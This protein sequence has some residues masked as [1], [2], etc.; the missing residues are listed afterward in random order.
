MGK[1]GKGNEEMKENP[2]KLGIFGGTSEGRL[3]AE[4]CQQQG[5]PA[6]VSVATEYGSQLLKEDAGLKVHIGRMERQEMC[7]WIKDNGFVHVVDATHP[8]AKEASENIKWAC[9]AAGIPYHRLVRSGNGE[10]DRPQ[11]DLKKRKTEEEIHWVSTVEEAA[12]FL[13]M[14]FLKYPKRTALITTGSKELYRFAAIEQAEERLYARVL[15]SI[16][17][18]QACLDAG[19]TGK[20]VI[21]MQGPFSYEMN[22]AMLQSTGASYLITKESGK[23][24]GFQEKADAALAAGCQLVVIGRPVQEQG[25]SLS[26]MEGWLQDAFLRAAP[27]QAERGSGSEER[28]ITLIGIGMGSLG[29]MTFDGILALWNSD[30]ILGASRM[31]ESGRAMLEQLAAIG[32]GREEEAHNGQEKTGS[33]PDNRGEA[34]KSFCVTYRP[35]EMIAWLDDHPKVKHPIILYSG[36]VGFYSGA[37]QFAEMVSRR[38]CRYRCRMLPGISSMAYFAARL[39]RSWDQAVVV[40]LHGREDHENWDLA[41]GRD[42]FLL[43]DGP[44]KLQEVCRR[45]MEQGQSE[46]RIW[47]GE[48]LSYPE[49]RIFSG[50]PGELADR[51]FGRLSVAWIAPAG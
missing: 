15:P 38:P 46:A 8:Y 42:R 40:S 18:I 11:E 5:I 16:E 45:L 50:T 12:D 1:T 13:S 48:R 24:G 7:R 30:A 31:V 39:G 35:E 14:E 51:V 33:K 37:E 36:D 32:F 4:F 20:H 47:I 41:D 44:Q 49:E 22:L 6:V 26:E 25:M 2:V 3:L 23:A 27:D 28:E 21:A 17:G 34:L 43:L 10:T 29:Q 9:E 19:L